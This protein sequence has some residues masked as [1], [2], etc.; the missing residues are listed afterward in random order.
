MS[1]PS[2]ARDAIHKLLSEPLSTEAVV[3]ILTKLDPVSLPAEALADAANAMMQHAKPFPSMPDM[4]DTCGTGGDGMHTR[5]V[6]TACAFV[7][8]ACDVTVIKHGNRAVSSKS[9]SADVLQA[10]GIPLSAREDQLMQAV[11]H[12]N[13]AF[14]FAPDYHPNLARL[15]E[16]RMAYGKRSIFNVLGPLCN[17]ARVRKQLLGVYDTALLAPMARALQLRGSTDAMIVHAQDGLDEISISA[18]SDM[19]WL[20]DGSI[21]LTSISPE[22]AGLITQAKGAIAGGSVDENATA[23]LELFRG[24]RDAYFDAVCF[25]SA[26]ALQVAGI[27][28]GWHE[29]VAIAGDAISSGKAM[30]VLNRYKQVTAQ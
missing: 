18:P 4:I 29:G 25:N 21:T 7:L 3:D 10:L 8:A 9:G 30:D 14:L 6:S 27:A 16:A 26:G 24:R 1:S 15:R 20:K 22:D 11:Q 17:P 13:L 28:H 12:C 19:A 2:Y 23:M 5:N